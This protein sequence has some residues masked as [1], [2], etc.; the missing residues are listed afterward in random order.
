MMMKQ[1][2]DNIKAANRM[3][4]FGIGPRLIFAGG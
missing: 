4:I 1:S 2:L 3:N